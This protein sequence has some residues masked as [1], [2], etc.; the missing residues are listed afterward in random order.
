MDESASTRPPVVAPPMPTYWV[1]RVVVA[2]LVAEGIWGLIVAFTHGLLLPFL[3]TVM[4]ADPQSP[5]YLGKGNL[6]VPIVFASVLELCFAGIVA[7]SLNA[8]ASR[9]TQTVRVKTI[10]IRSAGGKAPASTLSI[11][12]QPA[13]SMVAAPQASSAPS[14]AGA[15]PVPLPPSP[16]ERVVPPAQQSD[17]GKQSAGP[18]KPQKSKEVYYN[19]VGEAISPM[20]EE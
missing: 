15:E 18:G 14:S 20:D 13:P 5:L 9:G 10:H 7:I 12:S 1:L 6:D 3:A 16:E 2:V 4:P 8:W 17:P 11:S 19:I